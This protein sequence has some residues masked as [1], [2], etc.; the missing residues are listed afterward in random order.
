M[1]DSVRYEGE[2]SV[3]RHR[4]LCRSKKSGASGTMPDLRV[5]L[6]SKKS[7]TKRSQLRTAEG[8]PC[9]GRSEYT[10]LHGV[11]LSSALLEIILPTLPEFQ[12]AAVSCKCF[13][14]LFPPGIVAELRASPPFRGS[15]VQLIW[16]FPA[17]PPFQGID[18]AAPI[19]P[20]ALE[21]DWLP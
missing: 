9:G 6:Q 15:L 13:S 12:C 21:R 16:L 18:L 1:V 2:G 19:T 11:R 5:V 20:E 4:R 14:H 3:W 10:T 7:S 8:G 17:G